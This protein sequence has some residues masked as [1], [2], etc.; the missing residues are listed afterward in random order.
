MIL[1]HSIV[2]TYDSNRGLIFE[3]ISIDYKNLIALQ[4]FNDEKESE[5]LVPKIVK[6]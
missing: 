1:D 3:L 6:N 2:Y 5:M 4:T